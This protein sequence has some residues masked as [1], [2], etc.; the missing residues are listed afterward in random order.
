MKPR[1]ALE[2]I[3]PYT[4]GKLKE[5][6]VKLASNENPLGPSPKALERLKSVLPGLS[7]YPDAAFVRLRQAVAGRLG[8]APENLIFGNGSDELL[9][10]A[11]GTYIE[12][13]DDAVTSQSTFS[14]YTFATVLFGGHMTY[15]PLKDGRFDLP[16]LAALTG[17]RTRI[18]F[19]CNPNNPTGTVFSG[20]ELSRFLEKVSRDVLVVLDEAYYEY[21]GWDE[22]PRSV[23]LLGAHP[24]VLILRTFSKI[25]GLAGL[26]VGYGIAREEVIRNLSRAKTPFNVNLAAQEAALAALEDDEFVE[27]SVAMNAEGKR[28]LYREFDRLGL[29]YYPTEA[30]FV[31]VHLNRDGTEV[32]ERI[33]DMGVTIR[34]LR[35]FGMADWIRVTVGTPEQNRLFISCLQR[36]LK[37]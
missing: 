28:Y 20:D 33:M 27:R 18:V 32:F 31:C 36:V 19:L 24:N 1:K 25:Y 4:P 15:A 34:P 8:V 37:G 10:L 26:R 16:A 22:F 23:E 29:R 9:C 13:G 21:V 14:E 5:G 30:N 35:S 17:P 12:E 11:A 7:L 2:T 6:A 3:V